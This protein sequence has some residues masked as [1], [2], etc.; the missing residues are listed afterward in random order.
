MSIKEYQ[1]LREELES[2]KRTELSFEMR[3]VKTEQQ[4]L[5]DAIRKE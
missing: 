2:A 5:R 4:Y 1:L 3:E